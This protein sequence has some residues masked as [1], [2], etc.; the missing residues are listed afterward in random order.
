MVKFNEDVE[1]RTESEENLPLAKQSTN[2][3]KPLAKS[4]SET[5]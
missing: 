3:K 4:K 5:R 1:S 2:P